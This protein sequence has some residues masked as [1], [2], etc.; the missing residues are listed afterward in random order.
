M[1]NLNSVEVS[2]GSKYLGVGV[3]KVKVLS[4]EDK[5]DFVEYL[6]K[7]KTGEKGIRFY[8]IKDTDKD[9]VKEIKAK[10]LKGFLI[11]C[12]VSNFASDQAAIASAV[13]A[14]VNVILRDR[15]YWTN[16]RDTGAP[17]IK[18]TTE[19]FSS[20]KEA[21][22]VEFKESFNKPLSD[23]DRAAYEAALTAHNGAETVQAGND[24]L[25]F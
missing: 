10:Q 24:N 23:S 3:H 17:V 21:V 22:T 19:Y 8:K 25:P 18:T 12:G 2:D 1:F 11:D 6:L 14:V 9:I 16:D 13:N 15:E 20:R 4:W 7:N 5:G